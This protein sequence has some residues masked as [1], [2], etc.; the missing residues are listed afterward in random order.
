MAPVL[1]NKEYKYYNGSHTCANHK[2][3]EPEPEEREKKHPP[4]LLCTQDLTVIYDTNLNGYK[5][6]MP[7]K[8]M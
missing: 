1:S 6:T 5:L 7:Y 4:P 8:R 2:T 3:L